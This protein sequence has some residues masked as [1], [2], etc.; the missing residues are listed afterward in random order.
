MRTLLLFSI[1]LSAVLVHAQP[2]KLKRHPEYKMYYQKLFD[3]LPILSNKNIKVYQSNL[4]NYLGMSMDSMDMKPILIYLNDSCSIDTKLY[5]NLY[6]NWVINMTSDR[7]ELYE[8]GISKSKKNKVLQKTQLNGKSVVLT[9]CPPFRLTKE[10]FILQFYQ[11]CRGLCD[12]HNV[13][14]IRYDENQKFEVVFGGAIAF[15]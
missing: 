6:N 4:Y 8:K 3:E 12:S 11:H 2:N 15:Q 13:Y 10:L 9:I 1:C 14:L 7:K 5:Y